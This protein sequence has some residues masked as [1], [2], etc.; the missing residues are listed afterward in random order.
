MN[1]DQLRNQLNRII[2]YNDGNQRNTSTYY[3][4]TRQCFL[5]DALLPYTKYYWSLAYF[6]KESTLIE[7]CK[8]TTPN[9]ATP[10]FYYKTPS[11]FQLD[12]KHTHTHAHTHIHTR[13]HEQNTADPLP[14]AKRIDLPQ[15]EE[16]RSC[17]HVTWQY[18]CKFI[19]SL[20]GN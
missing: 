13:T 3:F 10:S 1:V 16:R 18:F 15:R 7:F 19:L 20:H 9:N 17:M 5:L 11:S 2:Y 12:N 6:R 8:I 4:N 14:F